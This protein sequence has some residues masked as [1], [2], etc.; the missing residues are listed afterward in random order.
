M[1][2]LNISWQGVEDPTGYLFSFA[3]S[4][5]AAVK[6]SPYEELSEDIVAASG[7]AFRLWVDGESL[8]PS[9]TSIWSFDSQKPW[10]ESGGLLCDYVGRY[11]GQDNIEEERRLKAIEII[12]K[13]IDNGIPA[14][15]W[16]ISV[17]E[18]GL[19]TGYDDAAE[20]FSTLAVNGSE[21]PLPYD[22]LGKR[23]LPIL[24]V[25]TVTGRSGKDSKQ[26]YR[27]TLRLA[28]SHLKGEEWCD[29]AKGL[30]AYPALIN[31]VREKITDSCRSL[32]YALGTYAGLRYY[33]AKYFKK[34]GPPV[35]AELYQTVY[36]N[37]K[38]A[39]DLKK[40]EDILQKPVREKIAG[41][42]ENARGLEEHA[43]GLMEEQASAD[44][45]IPR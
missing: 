33:A 30:A 37:W 2:K 27:D 26:I 8:C 38:A 28:V 12:R 40:T 19:I 10:V 23:D 13:S 20:S 36:E 25:L 39:F 11:W 5:S 29:N 34:Y 24:S 14:V 45:E 1:K 21:S 3:K 35:L 9:E 31:Y 4:L 18:W 43:L 17:P 16:D 41:L 32:E 15:S 6:S 7:F 42:L 44:E 22:K